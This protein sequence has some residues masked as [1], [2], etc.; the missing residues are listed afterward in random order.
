MDEG[1]YQGDYMITNNIANE[2]KDLRKNLEDEHF[3]DSLSKYLD[4]GSRMWQEGFTYTHDIGYKLDENK[5]R[6]ID[7]QDIKAY[8]ALAKNLNGFDKDDYNDS[9]SDTVPILHYDYED[10]KDHI[11]IEIDY[12]KGYEPNKVALQMVADAFYKHDIVLHIDAGPY[13]INYNNKSESEEILGIIPVFVNFRKTWQ[14]LIN[15]HFKKERR[16]KFYH[17]LYINEFVDA[18]D[19]L[20]LADNIPGMCF[21][22]A[23]GIFKNDDNDN[24]ILEAVNFMHELGHVLGL[25]HGGNEDLLYKPNYLSVM[26]YLY[27]NDGLETDDR[28]DYSIY[29]LPEIKNTRQLDEHKGI[30]PDNSIKERFDVK[31]TLLDVNTGKWRPYI[32]KDDGNTNIDFNRNNIIESK[33]KVDFY[34]PN[35]RN[36]IKKS[37]NDWEYLTLKPKKEGNFDTMNVNNEFVYENFDLLAADRIRCD[38]SPRPFYI[39]H[40]IVFNLYDFKQYLYMSIENERHIKQTIKLDIDSEILV[41]PYSVTVDLPPNVVTTQSIS[42]IYFPLKP[43]VTK[44][45]KYANA[46]YSEINSNHRGSYKPF[47][48]EISFMEP[49]VNINLGNS[50]VYVEYGFK[51]YAYSKILKDSFAKY[52]P[53]QDVHA[54]KKDNDIYTSDVVDNT[55]DYVKYDLSCRFESKEQIEK[56]FSLEESDI[57]AYRKDNYMYYLFLIIPIAFIVLIIIIIKKIIKFFKS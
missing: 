17:C 16:G 24:V 48:D 42:R 55:I 21:L 50:D 1:S 30:D 37:I 43:N 27:S 13:S 23:K 10:S 41:K 47:F 29:E 36:Y 31:W 2:Y 25:H 32:K 34:I 3:Y 51:D 28:L 49:M 19:V 33:A 20:G 12:A 18:K 4:D 53:L 5:E 44:L 57:M 15:L 40:G 26:N 14:L 7:A 52:D 11:F 45:Y 35:Y 54:Y 39:D 8:Y 46:S 6:V 9:Y 38:D 22:S 56:V